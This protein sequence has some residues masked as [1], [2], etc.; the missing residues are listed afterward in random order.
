M[1]A[2][3]SPTHDL[4]LSIAGPA[5]L[6]VALGVTGAG[7]AGLS[8]ALTLP[9]AMLGTTALMLP[10]LYIGGA[11]AGTD[12]VARRMARDTVG[13]LREMGLACIGF[14]PAVLFLGATSASDGGAVAVALALT[15]AALVGLRGLYVRMLADRDLDGTKA[16]AALV[17]AAWALVAMGIGARLA[18]PAFA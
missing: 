5:A 7:A 6:G 18:M 4:V 17:F 14:A 2:S 1:E 13:A 15:F 11:L 10:A 12:T 3:T 8:A 16:K 9:A